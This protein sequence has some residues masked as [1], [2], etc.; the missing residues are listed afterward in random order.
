MH[1]QVSMWDGLRMGR[2]RKTAGEEKQSSNR[3]TVYFTKQEC[4]QLHA[5]DERKHRAIN[6]LVLLA[7]KDRAQGMLNLPSSDSLATFEEIMSEEDNFLVAHVLAWTRR[8]LSNWSESVLLTTS[9]SRESA[10]AEAL[11]LS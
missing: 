11:R 9:S 10:G 6:Q 5:L 7:I 1:I 8:I 2:P 3:L 4:E